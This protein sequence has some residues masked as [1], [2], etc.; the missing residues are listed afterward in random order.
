MLVKP[1]Q[2]VV[3]KE[4]LVR[5]NIDNL[6]DFAHNHL[7]LACDTLLYECAT[8]SEARRPGMISRYKKLIDA[9]AYYCSC[10][11]K[12][13]KSEA[14]NCCPYSWFLPDLEATQQIRTTEVRL[15]DALD[16]TMAAETYQSHCKVA[17]A[18]FLD[19][20]TKLK[21]RIDIENPDV[22]KEIRQL[23]TNSLERYL[24]LFECIDA[25]SLHQTR[26][27]SIRDEWI[28]D[29]MKFCSSRE[30]MTWQCVRLTDAIV[31]NYYYIGQTGGVPGDD[32]AEHDYQDMEYVLLLS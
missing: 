13:I 11:V 24:H 23:P 9:G 31:Q 25:H 19:L 3:D 4:A 16:P 6:C 8:T 30:W 28:K 20:S 2:I 14:K 26:V 5:I 22:G 21:A 10:S 32:R 15:E 7:L 17:K 1:K 29:K 18:I 12:Y 27:D